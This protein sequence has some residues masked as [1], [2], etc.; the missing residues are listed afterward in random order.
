MAHVLQRLCSVHAAQVHKCWCIIRCARGLPHYPILCFS[1]Y[2]AFT[3]TKQEPW[4]RTLTVDISIIKIS[5][6][7]GVSICNVS[8]V[9]TR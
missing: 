4:A 6:A 3:S 2:D 1:S 7:I 5:A 9:R 8:M